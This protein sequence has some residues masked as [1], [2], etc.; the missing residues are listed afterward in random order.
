MDYGPRGP[1]SITTKGNEENDSKTEPVRLEQR[2]E[3]PT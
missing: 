1:G 2:E 3:M